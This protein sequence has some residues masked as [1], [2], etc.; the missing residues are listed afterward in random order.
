MSKDEVNCRLCFPPFC[1]S[2]GSWKIKRSLCVNCASFC[3]S[4]APSAWKK[5]STPQEFIHPGTRIVEQRQRRGPGAIHPEMVQFQDT[6]GMELK[7]MWEP[8]RF[9]FP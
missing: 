8:R 9:M 6:D 4:P 1:S 5:F 3:S 7:P 2:P